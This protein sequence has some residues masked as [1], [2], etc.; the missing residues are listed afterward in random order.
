MIII[1]CFYACV[2][3]IG[4]QSRIKTHDLLERILQGQMEIRQEMAEM[5]KDWSKVCIMI[6][7]VL[8]ANLDYSSNGKK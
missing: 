6:K 1:V 3:K 8:F 4:K 2:T 5:K 7:I